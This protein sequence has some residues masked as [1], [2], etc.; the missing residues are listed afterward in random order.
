MNEESQPAAYFIVNFSA[1]ICNY[2]SNS[3]FL[4]NA[5]N[6]RK[7]TISFSNFFDIKL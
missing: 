4:F 3:R 2:W 7:I 6:Y 5:K 1:D